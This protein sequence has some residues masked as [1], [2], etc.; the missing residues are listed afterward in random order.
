MPWI[1]SFSCSCSTCPFRFYLAGTPT[2][3][4]TTALQR[5]SAIDAATAGVGPALP[6]GFKSG[7]YLRDRLGGHRQRIHR[8]GLN[9]F[10]DSVRWD[11]L[12]GGRQQRTI[13][14]EWAATQLGRLRHDIDMFAECM[15]VG[16]AECVRAYERSDFRQADAADRGADGVLTGTTHRR[17]AAKSAGA[18]IR[19]LEQDVSALQQMLTEEA[20]KAEQWSVVG[21]VVPTV[22]RRSSATS[23]LFMQLRDMLQAQAGRTVEAVDLLHTLQ[24]RQPAPPISSAPCRALLQHFFTP[25]MLQG[26]GRLAGERFGALAAQSPGRD[27]VAGSIPSAL[28]L[29]EMLLVTQ[30]GVASILEQVL[31]VHQQVFLP[32]DKRA[33]ARAQRT[34]VARAEVQP[35]C[36]AAHTAAAATVALFTPPRSSPHSSPHS[37]SG[38]SS[39]SRSSSPR[40]SSHR[41]SGRSSSRSRPRSRSRSRSRSPGEEQTPIQ[42]DFKWRRSEVCASGSCH[43]HTIT[44]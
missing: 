43:F 6:E 29:M 42:I 44:P 25:V 19:G 13:Q 35:T 23:V 14:L 16:P 20:T 8:W 1:A 10:T 7:I 36:G 22:P 18:T 32:E 4:M 39:S 21:R 26:G 31:T 15:A 3:S 30:S 34:L 38:R 2:P 41:S 24:Q 27:V 37:R 17:A 11:M 12:D 28:M 5:H 9:T 33:A 40:S